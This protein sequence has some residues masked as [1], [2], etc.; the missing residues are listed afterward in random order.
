MQ[1]EDS[2]AGR[3]LCP[4]ASGFRSLQTVAL[5]LGRYTT[6]AATPRR[7]PTQAGHLQ[8][9]SI[10]LNPN[11][12]QG[13][14]Q[15][16]PATRWRP[17]ETAAG[18]LVTSGAHWEQIEDNCDRSPAE[19]GATSDLVGRREARRPLRVVPV[20]FF[21]RYLTTDRAWGILGVVHLP[22]CTSIFSMLF[23]LLCWS[24]MRVF[25]SAW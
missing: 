15:G 17:E 20:F 8:N 4:W 16:R 24:R 12:P 23:Q 11:N 5:Q 10:V 18:V 22:S 25:V 2:L 19:W 21:F 13:R 14:K 6:G 3:S 9:C 7:Q 1:S